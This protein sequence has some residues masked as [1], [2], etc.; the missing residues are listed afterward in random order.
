MYK[1]QFYD[2]FRSREATRGVPTSPVA[3]GTY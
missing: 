1:E 2:I 3:S